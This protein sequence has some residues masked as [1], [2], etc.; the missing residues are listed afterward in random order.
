MIFSDPAD[1]PAGLEGVR[2][3]YIGM[4][5]VPYAIV[6]AQAYLRLL[7]DYRLADLAYKRTHL[8]LELIAI[9]EGDSG[10]Q[11]WSL[12]GGLHFLRMAV[13]LLEVVGYVGGGGMELHLKGWVGK[14]KVYDVSCASNR[15]GSV[16]VEGSS[17]GPA[18]SVTRGV[19]TSDRRHRL[20]PYPSCH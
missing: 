12:V 17:G 5:A 6:A 9:L 3:D 11:G 20:P 8:R 15:V 2:V 13:T 14:R 4:E 10:G 7:E 1:T 18:T 16:G 19:E